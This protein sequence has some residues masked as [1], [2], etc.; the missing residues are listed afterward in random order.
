MASRASETRS[1]HLSMT[2]FPVKRQRGRSSGSQRHMLSGTNPKSRWHIFLPERHLFTGK[3]ISLQEN[4]YLSA[5]K[6]ICLQFAL[7]GL[8]IMNGSLFLGDSSVW[9]SKDTA[10][11]PKQPFPVPWVRLYSKGNFG[12][13]GHTN[14]GTGF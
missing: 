10:G 7:G 3:C 4:V 14:P 8:R 2:A 12:H 5:G 11:N 6:P 9:E 1:L 13:S